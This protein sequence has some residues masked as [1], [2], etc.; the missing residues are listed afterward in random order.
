MRAQSGV[1]MHNSTSFA[2]Y[3]IVPTSH[4]AVTREAARSDRIGTQG[5]ARVSEATRTCLPVRD[6]VNCN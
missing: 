2:L 1:V 4:A 6:K 3:G 5:S